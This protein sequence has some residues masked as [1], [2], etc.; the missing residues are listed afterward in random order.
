MIVLI[1]QFEF[2]AAS[3][4]RILEIVRSMDSETAKESNCVFYK[5]AIDVHSDCRLI[6]SEIWSSVAALRAHFC[7]P[8]FRAFRAA[9]RELGLQSKVVQFNG[10]EVSAN[11]P[12][13]WKTLLH[14]GELY[15]P[16]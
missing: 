15:S 12:D 9:S 1:A 4:D 14:E 6:L 13:H 8:H 10:T 16:Q 5:H 3:R 2:P 11:S 7:S